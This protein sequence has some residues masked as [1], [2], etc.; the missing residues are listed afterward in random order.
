MTDLTRK[1]IVTY[2]LKIRL[3]FENAYPT[4]SD[5][6]FDL[7]VE[8]WYDALKEYPKAVCDKAMN[9][10]LKKAKFAPRL[11]DI[12]EEIEAI[13]NANQKTDEEL[14]VELNSV[15]SRAYEISRYIRYP[16]YVIW[17][18][19]KLTEI[20]NSLDRAIQLYVV[21][22][23]TLTELSELTEEALHYEKTRFLKQMPVLRKRVRER[24]QA[25]Q[26]LEMVTPSPT[27]T[28]GRKKN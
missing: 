21:N 6:E 9:N 1:D 28:D 27:L 2:I 11:G 25:Q 16:Q 12:T 18:Q 24:E 17:A 4:R 15:L 7:L 26:L 10:A 5:G 22:I 13:L 8:S 3:N 14:W 19:K 20:Y 23:S